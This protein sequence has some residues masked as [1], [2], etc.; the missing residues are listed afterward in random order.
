MSARNA[1]HHINDDA[2]RL[3]HINKR[4]AV[5]LLS[6]ETGVNDESL[7]PSQARAP[8]EMVFE[9]Y[10]LVAIT[11]FRCLTRMQ[12]PEQ[13]HSAGADYMPTA[14]DKRLNSRYSL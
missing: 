3:E 1:A 7:D 2:F 5:Q 10:S 9:R 14:T 4:Q 13:M 12:F 6:A 11:F 8:A